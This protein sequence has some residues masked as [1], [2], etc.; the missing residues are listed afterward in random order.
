MKR[1][2]MSDLMTFMVVAQEQSFTRAAAKLNLSQSAISHTLRKL[3][4]NLDVRN[5]S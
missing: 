1:E 2:E 3:E 4:R 5:D